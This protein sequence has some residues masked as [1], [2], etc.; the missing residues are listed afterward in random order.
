MPS[1]DAIGVIHS[2]KRMLE[3]HSPLFFVKSAFSSPDLGAK[4]MKAVLLVYYLSLQCGGAGA[5]DDSILCTQSAPGRRASTYLEIRITEILH[6]IGVPAHIKGY[7]YLRDSIMMAFETPDIINAVTKQLYPLVAKRYETT[8]SRVKEP[9]VM[10]LK[11]LGI[12]AMWI[13]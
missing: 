12:E 4:I 5:A 8:S 3:D 1:L 13:F 10:R 11:W 2:A 6:Q 9:F 7:H